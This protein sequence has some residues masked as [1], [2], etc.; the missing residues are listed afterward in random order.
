M[1]VE[2]CEMPGK[3]GRAGWLGVSGHRPG[4]QT[5]C[6]CEGGASERDG[7]PPADLPGPA[8]NYR[9]IWLLHFL[10]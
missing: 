5:S 9:L 4:H 1:L 2:S 7:A 8:P 6:T 10:D 3:E